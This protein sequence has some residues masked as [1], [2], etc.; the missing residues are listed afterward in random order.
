MKFN[1]G[2]MVILFMDREDKRYE[3]MLKRL[4]SLKKSN[5]KVIV[6]FLNELRANGVGMH[7]GIQAG[8]MLKRI[9]EYLGDKFLN[10]DRADISAFMNWQKDGNIKDRTRNHYVI[11]LK[12][13]Y[14]WL[15][16]TK[17]PPEFVDWL[18]LKRVE[19]LEKERIP[20]EKVVSLIDHM[21]NQRDKVLTMLLYESGVRFG[22]AV[23]LKRKD[24]S[25]S[26]S[27]VIIK[28]AG[29]EEGARKTGQREVLIIGDTIAE[30]RKYLPSRPEDPDTYLFPM[31]Y[32]DVNSSC[33]YDSYSKNLKKAMKE[34][35][36][37]FNIHAHLFR[38]NYASDLV[39][40]GVNQGILE[41]QLGWAKAS[42]TARFYVDI[43]PEAQKNGILK[44]FGKESEE[45]KK[46]ESIETKNCP[47][48]GK[49][50]PS[51]AKY[52]YN[53]FIPLDISEALKE[54]ERVQ[55]VAGAMSKISGSGIDRGLL[56]VLSPESME[57]VVLEY[58]KRLKA[59]GKFDLI[60]KNL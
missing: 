47:R 60:A 25:F 3:S 46:Q 6:D 44:A 43:L 22:E 50:N 14:K 24:I 5:K 36:L 51:Y 31:L 20:R 38:S 30:M 17:E 29:R 23:A 48:C 1:I 40:R 26:A 35:G 4:E 34:A 11:I 45:Q 57:E 33:N 8:G 28:V 27:G 58:L 32:G 7:R 54:Q 18:I 37:D 49:E 15:F 13:F 9:A 39:E 12:Q 41:K 56:N 53:C 21:R 19:P 55:Q 42:R 52:C 10:P 59:E 2:I 16:K